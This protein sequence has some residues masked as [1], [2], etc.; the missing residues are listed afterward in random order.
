MAYSLPVEGDD[1]PFVGEQV[2][3]VPTCRSDQTVADARKLLEGSD[4]TE[5]VVVAGDDLAVGLVDADRLE[6]AADDAP[7]LD[8]MALVP[9][10]IRPSVTVDSLGEREGERAL[11]TT[12]DGRLLGVAEVKGEQQLEQELDS[13]MKAVRERF[14]DREPSTDELHQFLR[15]RLVDEGRSP[16]EADRL[17][18]ELAGESPS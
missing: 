12:S 13:L 4:A 1:G 2:T 10:S 16:E 3:P 14:G 8:V 17:M 5:V 7:L 11:V 6:D 15:D 9:S 18:A